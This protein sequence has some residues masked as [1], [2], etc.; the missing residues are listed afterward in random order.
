VITPEQ[1]RAEVLRYV[2]GKCAEAI[3]GRDAFLLFGDRGS[4]SEDEQRMIAGTLALLADEHLEE[5]EALADR[6]A[7]LHHAAEVTT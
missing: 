4:R 3:R 1:A 2:A 6:P 7:M 5:A